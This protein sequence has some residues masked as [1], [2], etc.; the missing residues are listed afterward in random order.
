MIEFILG[1]LIGFVLG[2]RAMLSAPD[3]RTIPDRV[4]KIEQAIDA[5]YLWPAKEKKWTGGKVVPT[6]LYKCDT[7]EVTSL[8]IHKM[9]EE[10]P[11]CP[12]CGADPIK[13][14]QVW[15]TP[16]VTKIV[17]LPKDRFCNNK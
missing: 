3:Y 6:Y 14:V 15:D 9:S 17:G 4:E 8:L 13:M 12:I 10:T 11:K 5:A 16:P 2:S 7:C 1:L